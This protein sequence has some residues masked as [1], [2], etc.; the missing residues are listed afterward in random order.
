MKTIAQNLLELRQSIF[1]AARGCGRDPKTI[2]LLAASKS[3]TLE[4]IQEAY[5]A[6]Q[7]VFGENYAQELRE[8]ASQLPRDIEW[9]MIGNVQ[10]K[11]FKHLLGHCQW[12][13]TLDSLELAETIER[14][15]L[16]PINTLVQ[17]N[18][19]DETSKSGIAPEQLLPFLQSIRDFNK[20]KVLGMMCLP[21]FFEDPEQSRPYFQQMR[22][23]LQSANAAKNFP[24][25]LTELS[26]GMSHDFHVAIQ[27][28]ATII[29]VGSALFPPRSPL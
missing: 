11:N 6:G 15:S 10:R 13:D 7:R 21:P 22:T 4:S 12:L 14:R 1:H 19:A 29:R 17:I 28:G 2:K 24:H 9:H 18:I 26:M 27:E 25:Q 20:I 8:K 5:N 23:L 16:E 3:Q